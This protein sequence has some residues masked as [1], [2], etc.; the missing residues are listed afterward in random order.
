MLKE[1]PDLI[2]VYGDVNSTLAA[3]LV[4]AKMGI[5]I[6]HVEAGL[7]SRDLR[8][9]EEINRL[10]TDRLSSFFFIPSPEAAANLIKENINK[11][12]IY[13]VGNVMIDTLIKF[14]KTIKSRK[15]IELPFPQFGIVTL[16][17]PSNVDNVDQLKK[18]IV[19]FNRIAKKIPLV[20]PI[21][22]RTKK[23]LAKIKDV[24]FDKKNI[25]LIEPL[26]YLDFLSLVYRGKLVITDSGGIQEETTYLGVPCLTLRSNTERPITISEGTNTLI[27][28]NYE[29][30]ETM[31]DK[32]LAKKYKQGNIPKNWD[33]KSSERI[34]KIIMK[35]YEQI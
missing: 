17:R 9:P 33:G 10:V 12:D 27:G 15:N 25:L 13:F 34:A 23:Q 24:K 7:R 20:F 19:S 31:I 30:L 18:I 5:K 35:K 4:G 22:P 3:A 26:G 11:K 8:M 1:K 2:L 16:H 32:I 29:L 6:G 28:D 14:L 21:H